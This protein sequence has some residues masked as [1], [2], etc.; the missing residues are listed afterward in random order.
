MRFIFLDLEFNQ[1][2]GWIVDITRGQ[3]IIQI[4]YTTTEAEFKSEKSRNYYIKCDYSDINEKVK[5]LT[6]ITFDNIKKGI[7]FTRAA[8]E[9]LN[10]ID[11]TNLENTYLLTWGDSDLRILK[12]NL[13]KHK[14][15]SRLLD[16]INVLDVQKIYMVK[17]NLKDHPALVKTFEKECKEEFSSIEDNHHNAFYDVKALMEVSKTLGASYILEN[18]D[19]AKIDNIPLKESMIDRSIK[20]KLSNEKFRKHYTNKFNCKFCGKFTK[21]VFN[22]YICLDI[23]SDR[24]YHSQIRYCKYCKRV[25]IK[26]E[27]VTTKHKVISSRV[28]EMPKDSPIDKLIKR[29]ILNYKSG[30]IKLNDFLSKYVLK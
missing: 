3:D 28:I 25:F 8:K 13:Y 15:N 12:R 4:A 2:T 19:I 30:E 24:R 9:F 29:N 23:I 21:L 18:Q 5:V 6:G 22:D 20:I 10:S 17:N 16:K 11:A 26:R 14:I 7:S 1:K 27:N